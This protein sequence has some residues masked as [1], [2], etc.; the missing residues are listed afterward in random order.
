MTMPFSTTDSYSS[1]LA[2]QTRALGKWFGAKP[3][4]RD[5]TLDLP[6]GGIHA[7]LGRNGAG[8]STLFRILLG[9]L[10]ASQGSSRVLGHDSQA[11]PTAA[12]A[13]IAF[14]DQEHAL[15]GWLSVDQLCAQQ[16]PLYERW[17]Q[18]AFDRVVD[19]FELTPGQ[20]VAE[21]SRGER[22]GLCL[23]LA[24]AQ[25]PRLMILDE[26]TLGLDVV[27][28]QAVLEAILLA[29]E[30]A[31][32]TLV[33]CSHHMDEVERI[34][35]SLAILERGR[36]AAFSEPVSFL[37]RFSSWSAEGDLER[38]SDLEG[39]LHHRLLDDR[40]HLVMLDRDSSVVQQLESLG[41]S[42]IRSEPI[43]FDGAMNAF[44]HRRGGHRE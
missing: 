18:K 1:D 9:F 27:A 2:L 42:Q 15:P 3:A 10:T 44:L 21:L 25:N 38:L 37:E 39:L 33:F 7:V 5:L 19:L 31:D 16:Q 14:V 13:D 43:T 22:A 40:H 6:Q 20:R 29:S 24:L 26:P 36:L 11:I 8:K 4:L 12:R 34:A 30:Q 35:D 23:A 28:N 17:D 32:R 41:A